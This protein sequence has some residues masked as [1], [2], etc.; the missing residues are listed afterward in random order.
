MTIS[1]TRRRRGPHRWRRGERV[2]LGAAGALVLGAGLQFVSSYVYAGNDYVPPFTEI[3][4]RFFELFAEPR[5]YVQVGET[6]AS[7][8][9]GIVVSTVFG[10]AVGTLFG[11][12]EITYLSSRTVIELIRPIPAVAVIPL[13]IVML[14]T[15]L[16]MKTFLVVFTCF[17][18]IL[19]NSLSGVRSVDPLMK[20]MARTFGRSR[21]DIVRSVVIPAALPM[22]WAG[23]RIASTVS[24][25]VVITL[26][27]VLGG[28]VGVGGMISEARAGGNDVHTAYAAILIS[29][30]LGLLVNIALT[31]VERRYFA[32]ST[33][34]RE[35]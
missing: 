29:G 21:I 7:F 6:M 22:M 31:A 8:L 2:A 14:G 16:G 27:L 28:T 17:F 30:V 34:T 20:D 10:V 24:L 35:G 32:W 25:I 11:L 26:E 5:L 9:L 1:T 23:V 18:P 12:S 13:A 4:A 19:F 33:T 3:V 15:N